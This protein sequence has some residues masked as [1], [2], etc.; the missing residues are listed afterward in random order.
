MHQRRLQLVLHPR[1][2]AEAS[3]HDAVERLRADGC[4]V[5]VQ[6]PDS[7]AGSQALAARVASSGSVDTVV[8][9]GGDGTINAVA[10]GLLSVPAARRPALGILP[11]GTAN[12]FAR[13][14]GIP[15]H[16]PLAALRLVVEQPAL[17]IDIGRCGEYCFVN[18]AT[19]GFGAE[20]TAAT[21]PALKQAL[22][23]VAYLLTGLSRLS[24]IHAQQARFSS[25]ERVWEGRFLGMAVGNGRYAGGGV[26]VCPDA[27]I[28]DGLLN[29][30]IV[31]DV[32]EADITRALA[33]FMRDGTVDAHIPRVG[34][35][36]ARLRIQP[37][38][39]LHINLDGEPL[40]VTDIDFTVLPAAL[41][42]HLPRYCPLRRSP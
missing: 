8:A 22:G 7:P 36:C 9:G 5:R 6:V 23:S 26:D 15:L 4:R 16:D 29:V 19:G 32:P 40:R 2:A 33:H 14:C 10:S 37:S 3:V 28:D 13:G 25:G 1:T 31:P 42:C 11:L 34:W 18:V 12:D 39:I 35:S 38:Q 21:D 20:V 41:R 24:G 17:P 27:R 30:T